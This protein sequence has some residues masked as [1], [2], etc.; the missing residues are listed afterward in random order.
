MYTNAVSTFT[1]DVWHSPPFFFFLGEEKRTFWGFFFNFYFYI[2]MMI[3]E[4]ILYLTALLVL[5]SIEA[6]WVAFFFDCLNKSLYI[7]KVFGSW[8]IFFFR[9]WK[10][11]NSLTKQLYLPTS[12]NLFIFR[13]VR[14]V[15][16]QPNCHSSNSLIPNSTALK[17]P[18]MQTAE[19]PFIVI[20]QEKPR[21]KNAKV[22]YSES[23]K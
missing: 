17:T 15:S 5:T 8:L 18:N 16:T 14:L 9:R 11:N 12:P 19:K 20:K 7:F 1:T 10:S 6:T 22:N 23:N 2:P 4:I 3:V 21:G 13:D